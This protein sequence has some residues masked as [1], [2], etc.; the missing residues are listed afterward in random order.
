MKIPDVYTENVNGRKIEQVRNYF[1]HKITEDGK[2]DGH[3]VFK[4]KKSK[5]KVAEN[6]LTNGTKM[7]MSIL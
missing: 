2:R 5:T 3:Y 1:G 7:S 6:N 4:R